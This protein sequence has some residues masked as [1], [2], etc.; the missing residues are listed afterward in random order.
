MSSEVGMVGISEAG[1]GVCSG[2][3]L[4]C[5]SEGEVAGCSGGGVCGYSDG[6]FANGG[7]AGCSG[8]GVVASGSGVKDDGEVVS[9]SISASET[10]KVVVKRLNFRDGGLEGLVVEGGVSDWV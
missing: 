1:G 7:F 6:G 5:C 2:G 4:G 8:G 9:F 10:S 3:E